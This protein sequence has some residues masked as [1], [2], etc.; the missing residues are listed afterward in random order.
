MYQY[1]YK[2][3]FKI[4]YHLWYGLFLI[5]QTEKFYFD[6]ILNIKF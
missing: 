4:Y 5:V 6:S 3:N 1:D 2:C